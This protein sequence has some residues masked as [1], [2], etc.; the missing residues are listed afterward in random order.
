MSEVRSIGQVGKCSSTKGTVGFSGCKDLMLQPTLSV[1]HIMVAEI[2]V[3]FCPTG[4]KPGDGLSSS[5]LV[6][7]LLPPQSWVKEIGGTSTVWLSYCFTSVG[8]GR[9]VQP[10]K[11]LDWVQRNEGTRLTHFGFLSSESLEE[12]RLSQQLRFPLP[13]GA[14]ALTNRQQ[15][16]P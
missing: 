11:T 12:A 9:N 15:W 2:C 16:K 7:K 5:K 8:W 13:H 3:T 6:S 14:S 4:A 1:P 10:L